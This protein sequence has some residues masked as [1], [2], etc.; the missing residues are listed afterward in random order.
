VRHFVTIAEGASQRSEEAP[1]ERDW[2]HEV[3]A[4]ATSG[5]T[6]WPS[7]RWTYLIEEERTNLAI[8]MLHLHDPGVTQLRVVPKTREDP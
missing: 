4:I 5:Q 7:S 2:A 1:S 3:A 8:A 6:P